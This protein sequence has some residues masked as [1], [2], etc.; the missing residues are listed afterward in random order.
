MVEYAS[1]VWTGGLTKNEIV[2]IERVQ[3]AAFAIIL[4]NKNIS[5]CHALETL[6]R[7]SLE[8]RRHQIN[9]R[10]ATKCLRSE[11]F[12]HW[13]TKLPANTSTINTRSKK[14]TGVAPVQFRT[15]TFAKSPIAYLTQ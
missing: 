5:Y 2:Q 8:S 6:A 1:P 9:L 3:K 15:Q 12:S 11:T 13:F 10:F 7:P 14:P 4:G